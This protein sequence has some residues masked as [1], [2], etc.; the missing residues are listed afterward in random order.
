VEASVEC[1]L[2][3]VT[4][5]LSLMSLVERFSIHYKIL[6]TSSLSIASKYAIFKALL[7]IRSFSTL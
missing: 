3:S 4:E 7:I 1:Q 6:G 5:I 2:R